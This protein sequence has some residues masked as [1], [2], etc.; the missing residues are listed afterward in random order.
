M[1]HKKKRWEYIDSYSL[2]GLW[3]P[4]INK[5]YALGY[6]NDN[7]PIFSIVCIGIP[8]RKIVNELLKTYPT[9]TFNF[10]YLEHYWAYNSDFD[11][12]I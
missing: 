6:K 1:N 2:T 10:E 3:F 8:S 4:A 5:T 12:S 9:D 7:D 11:D